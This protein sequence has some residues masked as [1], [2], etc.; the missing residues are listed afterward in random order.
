MKAAKLLLALSFRI[1]VISYAIAEADWTADSSANRLVI[2]ELSSPPL[3]DT[4]TR[5]RFS[6]PE[7]RKGGGGGERKIRRECRKRIARDREAGRSR[8]RFYRRLGIP[9]RFRAPVRII[10]FRLL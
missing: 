9:I 6:S 4:A 7:R 1:A 8:A 5:G 3:R 10:N 2:R